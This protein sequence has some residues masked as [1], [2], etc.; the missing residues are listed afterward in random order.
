MSIDG[1]V[2]R[3]SDLMSIVKLQA[4]NNGR[5]TGLRMTG[6]TRQQKKNIVSIS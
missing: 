6:E 5:Q 3:Y 1:K 2:K 4:G